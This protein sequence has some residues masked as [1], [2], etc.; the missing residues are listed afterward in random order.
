VSR[1]KLKQVEL[2][3]T[4]IAHKGAA[5]GRTA[6]GMVV[7]IKDVVP[8][9]RV[10]ALL[11]KKLKGT[12][13][14][15]LEE[16]IRPS[17][18]RIQPDCKHFGVCGGCSW[19]QLDY[20]HQLIHKEKLVADSLIRIGKINPEKIESILP[21]PEIFFYRNKLEFTFSTQKWFEEKK[22]DNDSNESREALGF[23]RPGIFYKV[24]DIEKCHLQIDI[25]NNIRNELRSW[26]LKNKIAFYNIRNHEGILR[27][28][29]IRS[30][31]EGQIMCILIIASPVSEIIK[32]LIDHLTSNYKEI[33]SFYT[34][35]N[36]KMNDSYYDLTYQKH[37][38]EDYLTQQLNHV[39]FLIGPK[40][41][42][43]PNPGQAAN[44]YSQVAAFAQLTG[45]EIVYDWY[46][47]VGSIGIYL[48]KNA[49]RVIGIEEIP[50]AINDAHLNA[51]ANGLD[52]CYFEVCSTDNINIEN[53]IQQHGSPDVMIVD[54]PRAGMN[55]LVIEHIKQL[56]PLRLIYVS[57]NPAT[58]ARDILLLSEFYQTEK[59]KPV[60][61]FPHTNHVE[62]VALLSLQE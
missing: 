41:F 55:P 10:S 9:D 32:Q 43:Q 22:V 39:K 52:N 21:A 51:D 36:E 8:G 3:I 25:S 46:C 56:K 14:G 38:G 54:P 61:M 57:C 17:T 62:S 6:D 44:L 18:F 20:N 49:A 45:K 53:M 23:H 1:K 60:D 30:N 34:I 12:W 5:V 24:V 13:Q 47:G 16:I 2:E 7:F 33:V 35:V 19:Q 15:R 50:E 11:T 28:L 4:G 48:A 40:S 42:F 27:N 31:T 29:I 59:V 37:F 26:C 58:Q